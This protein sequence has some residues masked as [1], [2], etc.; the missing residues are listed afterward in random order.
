MTMKEIPHS[1]SK[2]FKVESTDP[3]RPN[4]GFS[5]SGETPETHEKWVNTI[6]ELFEK[7]SNFI[8]ILTNLGERPH[9]T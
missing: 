9:N 4:I 2:K 7:Q 1:D 5:C 8:R 3:Q 6:N